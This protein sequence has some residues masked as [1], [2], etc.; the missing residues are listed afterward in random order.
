M[1]NKDLTMNSTMQAKNIDKIYDEQF[2][3]VL[4]DLR[5]VYRC[6]IVFTLRSFFFFSFRLLQTVELISY[7]W[8]C[9]SAQRCTLVLLQNMYTACPILMVGNLTL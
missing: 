6:L 4:Y 3:L 7:P 8:Y 5:F 1:Q 9:Q 2:C